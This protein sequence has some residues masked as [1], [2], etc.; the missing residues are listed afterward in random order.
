MGRMLRLPV[1][2]TFTA[3]GLPQT[4]GN[5]SAFVAGGRAVMREGRSKEANDRFKMWRHTVSDE[6]RRVVGDAPLLEGPLWMSLD[7]RLPKPASAPKR[8]RTW[9]TAARSGDLDK[10]ARAC[11]DALTGVVF[12]DDA[13]VVELGARKDYGEPGVTV[14]LGLIGEDL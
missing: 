2:V 7:F 13:Q 10:L 3:R 1:Q 6:A 12:A 11:L 5:K 14:R 4:Q 9:P 8:K